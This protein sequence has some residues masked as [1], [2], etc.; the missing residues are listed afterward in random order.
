MSHRS[1]LLILSDTE[2][3]TWLA[4]SFSYL[5]FSVSVASGGLEGLKLFSIGHF[6]VVLTDLEM[7]GLSGSHVAQFVRTFNPATLILGLSSNGEENAFCCDHILRKSHTGESL[8]E[9]VRSLV[10]R[11]M[12]DTDDYSEI[13]TLAREL[14]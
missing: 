4:T 7:P 2:E 3:R 6:D 12:D 13:P 10:T 5:G 8:I 14:H 1:M 11:Y 9:R